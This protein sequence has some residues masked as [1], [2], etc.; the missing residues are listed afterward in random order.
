MDPTPDLAAAAV[1]GMG[2]ASGLAARSVVGFAT[3]RL[4]LLAGGPPSARADGSACLGG[5][6]QGGNGGR[7]RHRGAGADRCHRQRGRRQPVTA[8]QQ[9][10]VSGWFAALERPDHDQ[11][12]A[13]RPAHHD[14]PDRDPAGYD[15]P[16]PDVRGAGRALGNASHTNFQTISTEPIGTIDCSGMRVVILVHRPETHRQIVR[17]LA[18]AYVDHFTASSVNDVVSAYDSRTQSRAGAYT[19]GR[20]ILDSKC[21]GYPTRQIEIDAGN[22]LG[23]YSKTVITH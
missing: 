11:S 5:V 12:V 4:E 19:A 22:A 15:Q 6:P 21:T 17:D 10:L 13:D 18:A 23:S 14:Q 2:T 7:G 9:W 1:A 3:T 20:L 8:G 16:T